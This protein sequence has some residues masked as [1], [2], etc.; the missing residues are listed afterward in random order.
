[1]TEK[2]EIAD[3]NSR[4]GN[5]RR[6]RNSVGIHR[7]LRESWDLPRLTKPRAWGGSGG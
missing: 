7:N 1:M 3:G 6:F 5:K 2:G 4:T